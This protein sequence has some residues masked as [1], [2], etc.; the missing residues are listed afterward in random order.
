M[1]IDFDQAMRLASL[2]PIA[3][4]HEVSTLLHYEPSVVTLAG[5]VIL[6]SHYG[7]PNFGENPKSDRKFRIPI[8]YLCAPFP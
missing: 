3:Y 4:N 6:E 7:P 2:L 5:R 1:M 8:L